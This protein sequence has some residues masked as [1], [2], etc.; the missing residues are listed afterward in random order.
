M[1]RVIF[2]G[3][4]IVIALLHLSALPKTIWEYDESLFC[5]GVENYDPLNHFPPPPGYPIYMGVAK[6]VAPLAGYVPFR[7]LVALSAFTAIAGFVL[8]AFGFRQLTGSTRAGALGAFLFYASPTMLLHATLP[9]S[10]SGA[11]ALLGLSMWLCALNVA[12][13][14]AREDDGR[15]EARPTLLAFM[16]VACAATIGWRLQFAIAVVPLFLTTTLLL[17]SWRER[18][19]A[20]QWFAIACAVWLIALITAC[21]GVDGFWKM[22]SGQAAYFAAHD[23]DISRT[24]RSAAQIALRFISHP[25]GPKWLA[26][27]VL[28]LAVL[29]LVDAARRRL[30]VVL[31]VVVMSAV[32]FGFALAMMDPADGVR[33][34][35]PAL[36]GIALLAAIG[37]DFLRRLSREMLVDWALLALYA[38][39]AYAYTGPLLRQRANEPSPPYAAIQYLRSVAPRNA[40]ILYDLPLKPH[41]Q[42]L[43]RGYTR[44]RVDEGLLRFGHRTDR[45]LYELTDSATEA[46]QGKVFRWQTP[47]AYTKLTRGHYGAA[48][49]VPLPVTQRFL[50]L[51]GISPPERTRTGSWR[52][53]GAKGIIALPELGARSVRLTLEVPGDYP[54]PLNRV[55]IDVTGG[56]SVG[57]IVSPGKKTVLDVPLP[58]GR[59]QLTITP[60]QTFVPA[61]VPGRLSRDRR[62]LSVML[63]GLEQLNPASVPRSAAPAP[64]PPAAA[65]RSAG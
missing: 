6:L 10:D 16:G 43:L 26:A 47:D 34:A 5:M 35:L 22:M 4:V 3:A 52:W 45:P 61:N 33:Y 18:F 41:A 13:A 42:Y 36:P 39:G 15:A 40:V 46:P 32:Y 63:T 51:G 2:A 21:G 17:R 38:F 11:L 8:L 54:L 1:Q 19:V 9:Q 64:A 24:G 56:A 49:V 7:A 58:P 12:R 50:A 25:W 29:G 53:I 14:S 23:A 57:G 44:L 59:A 60:E 55:R 20:V 37:I 27:P 62:T 30:R 31:P 28:F 48:S 65:S